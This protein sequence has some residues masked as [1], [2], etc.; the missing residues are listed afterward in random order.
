MRRLVLLFLALTSL[1]AA[2]V[3][4]ARAADS[5]PVVTLPNTS[6]GRVEGTQAFIGLSLDGDRLRVYVCNGTAKRK[7]TLSQ[8]FKG[9]WDGR[10]AL[11]LPSRPSRAPHRVG[12]AWGRDHRTL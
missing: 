3:A 10:A 5:A 4:L 12:E 8:W 11:T 6:V 2:P 7:A 1:F 9:R